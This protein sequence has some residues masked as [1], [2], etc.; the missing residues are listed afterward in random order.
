MSIDRLWDFKGAKKGNDSE[1][2]KG[3]PESWSCPHCTFLNFSYIDTCTACANISASRRNQ[4]KKQQT[5]KK[6][7]ADKTADLLFHRDDLL[8]DLEDDDDSEDD[9]QEL[10]SNGNASMTKINY[11][12]IAPIHEGR[13]LHMVLQLDLLIECLSFLGNPI[14]LMNLMSTCKF[15]TFISEN[16][17]IWWRFQSIFINDPISIPPP[18]VP[19]STS[20]TSS[21]SQQ[22]LTIPDLTSTDRTWICNQCQ[23]TQA[24]SSSTHC[25]MCLSERPVR[26]LIPPTA[27][28]TAFVI[29]KSSEHLASL[30]IEGNKQFKENENIRRLSALSDIE[31]LEFEESE[32]ET[33]CTESNPPGP[34]LGPSITVIDSN[35]LIKWPYHI[36]LPGTPFIIEREWAQ[37]TVRVHTMPQT[38][39][40][41]FFRC[42]VA[43]LERRYRSLWQSMHRGWEWIRNDV[44]TRLRDRWLRIYLKEETTVSYEPVNQSKNTISNMDTMKVAT[45]LNTAHPNYQAYHTCELS[46]AYVTAIRNEAEELKESMRASGTLRK[47]LRKLATL[48]WVLCYESIKGEISLQAEALALDMKLIWDGLKLGVYVPSENDKNAE[49]TGT[50]Y[51]ELSIQ[52]CQLFLNKLTQGCVVLISWAD[53]LEENNVLLNDLIS[54]D[55]DQ[56]RD[57]GGISTK[58]IDEKTGMTLSPGTPGIADMALL[59]IRNHVMLSHWVADAVKMCITIVGADADNKADAYSTVLRGKK[60]SIDEISC[61]TNETRETKRDRQGRDIAP[62]QRKVLLQMYELCEVLD[63]EDDRLSIEE[64]TQEVFQRKYIGPIRLLTCL[65]S[66]IRNRSNELERQACQ[67]RSTQWEGDDIEFT[68]MRERGRE[69]PFDIHRDQKVDTCIPIDKLAPPSKHYSTNKNQKELLTTHVVKIQAISSDIPYH[70]DFDPGSIRRRQLVEAY[71]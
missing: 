11:L 48:N 1:E 52:S 62:Q 29:V 27:V 45:P 33:I 71:L 51:M 58:Q 10:S 13:Q 25:E 47:A 36:G 35:P 49:L 60:R 38:A 14:D 32:K 39:G 19:S 22:L 30:W 69:G 16:D 61:E 21:R 59:A 44:R 43:C 28:Q 37:H 7:L 26:D 55:R 50:N 68:Y 40:K 12:S 3:L 2:L 24:L 9:N 5:I 66:S 42:K 17:A 46:K 53:E 15:F 70:A 67:N 8:N 64:K 54:K 6:N 18:T 65:A 4:I 41:W 31:I 23:L 57:G 34:S 63:I 56:A 20:T